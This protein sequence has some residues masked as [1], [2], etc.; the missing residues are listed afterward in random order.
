MKQ[1]FA[2][3]I[4]DRRDNVALWDGQCP[5]YWHRKVAYRERNDRNKVAKDD[6][7]Y[8]VVKVTVLPVHR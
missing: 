4:V 1:M 6:D 8:R 2:W 3:A 5:I 7:A